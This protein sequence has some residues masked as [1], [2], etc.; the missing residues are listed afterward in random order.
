VAPH[1]GWSFSGSIA[2]H[3][4]QSIR[5]DAETIV[6]IGGHLAP[7]SGL[8]AAPEEGYE[9]PLGVL[10]A[11]MELLGF[12]RSK[13][14]LGEDGYAD[15]TVEIQLPLVKYLHPRAQALHLRASPSAEALHLG[16][17]LAAASER[18][19]RRIAVVG[20][21]DLTHYGANYGFTPKGCGAQAVR[22]VKEVND[23]RIIDALLEMEM[24]RALELAGQEQSACSVG[25]AVAAARFAEKRGA[26]QGELLEYRTSYDLS[27][28]PFFVGYAGII[29]PGIP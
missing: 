5:A 16:D 2:C 28:A 12:L 23:R 20:S 1:A 13:L 18:L 6:V 26:A 11:D 17:Q 8:L 7:R 21:T 24:E 19:G 15:N 9:T 3:V 22:W 25:G 27:P 4:F 14:T 29:Y 10:A